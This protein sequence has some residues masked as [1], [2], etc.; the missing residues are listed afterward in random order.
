MVKGRWVLHCRALKT[1]AVDTCAGQ[2]FCRTDP[3]FYNISFFIAAAG[4]NRNTSRIPFTILA[5]DDPN[6]Y[7]HW[8]P[9]WISDNESP[10]TIKP[11]A[12]S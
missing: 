8:F 2:G 12:I 10:R 11:E 9:L 4:A 1:P 6:Y 3:H 7:L 5:S